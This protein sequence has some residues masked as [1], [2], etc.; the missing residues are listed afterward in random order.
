MAC[1]MGRRTGPDD[2]PRRFRKD[3][4]KRLANK[5]I[6]REALGPRRGISLASFYDLSIEADCAS[7]KK[8][9][10]S[11]DVSRITQGDHFRHIGIPHDRDTNA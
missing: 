7:P 3:P 6:G 11:A 8:I 5:S 4:V 2:G 9:A 1:E 10:A